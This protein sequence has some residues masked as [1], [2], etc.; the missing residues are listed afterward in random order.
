MK[1]HYYTLDVRYK[2][3]QDEIKKSYRKLAVKFH[4]DKHNGDQY[5]VER[6]SE[7]QE[8]Y[9]ILSD[10]QRRRIFDKILKVY[11]EE[12]EIEYMTFEKYIPQRRDYTNRLIFLAAVLITFGTIYAIAYSIR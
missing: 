4:P 3:T 9:E 1:N 11:L 10:V 5:F 2:A 6:F 7:I 8:A 12:K